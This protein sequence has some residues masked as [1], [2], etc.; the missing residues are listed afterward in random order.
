M[1][2]A[3]TRYTHFEKACKYAANKVIPLKPK[4]KKRIP[5]KTAKHM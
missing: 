1:L 2:Y 4:L 5:W 3:S